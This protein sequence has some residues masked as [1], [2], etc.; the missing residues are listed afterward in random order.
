[1]EGFWWNEGSWLIS[2]VVGF[3]WCWL[4]IK[5]VLPRTMDWME[6]AGNLFLAAGC[7]FLNAVLVVSAFVGGL[8]GAAA[9]FVFVAHFMGC[10]WEGGPPV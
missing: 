5:V 4:V 8:G 3:G 6:G 2:I 9:L 10:T 1:M 7:W